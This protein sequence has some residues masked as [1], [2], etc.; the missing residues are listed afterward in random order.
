MKP[1]VLSRRKL[2]PMLYGMQRRTRS[3][4]EP[5]VPSPSHPWNAMRASHLL[6]RAAAL[7]TWDE[8]TTAAG[9]SPGDVVDLLLDV[10]PE[11]SPPGAWVSEIAAKPTTVDEDNAYRA[12][13]T[14]NMNALRAWWAGLM[15]STGMNI[16]E[17]MTLFWHGHITSEGVIV[18]VPQFMYQQNALFRSYALGNFRDLMK[19]VNHDP[20]MLRYLDG[21]IN[22][23]S[24]PN[25]NYARELMELYTMG[26][27]KYTEEDIREAAR[28]LTGWR[29]DE[30][31]SFDASFSPLYHDAGNKTFM[32]RTIVGKSSLDGRFEGDEVVDIIFEDP[33]VAKFICRKLYLAFVYNNPAAVDGE[34]VDG[35]A[36]IFRESNY[37][38]KPVIAAL[39]KSAHFFDVVNVGAM[40][41]SPAV[42]QVGLARQLGADPGGARLYADMKTLE[43]NLLDPPNVA[44]WEGYRT[45]VS[46]TT[47]PYRKSF[48]ERFITGQAPGGASQTPMDVVSWGKKFDEYNNAE[49]LIDQ[50]LTL[51]LPVAVS[52]TRRSSYLQTMLG[53][54]PVYEWNIDA[55]NADTNLRGTLQRIVSAPD[56]QLH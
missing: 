21:E 48:A 51:L 35:L 9:M 56:F 8:I 36:Q 15:T 52:D 54:A 27:G 4:L 34:I 26:E 7:P 18:L 46:T 3:G 2:P 5:Y 1:E 6:R 22:I 29:L 55:P 39:L 16:R 14:S 53:G 47:Y 11:P 31:A 37:D 30:F 13:N 41:K 28:C 38:I 23:G 17:V 32:G 40:I 49:K 33:A 50:M 19:A 43:Q 44:G 45:W 10:L 24:N 20:A 42:L 12:Q 25:E